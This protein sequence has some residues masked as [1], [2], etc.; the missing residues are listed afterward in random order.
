MDLR[1][2]SVSGNF[3]KHLFGHHSGFSFLSHFVSV[4]IVLCEILISISLQ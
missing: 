3:H 4:Y 2:K 1:V